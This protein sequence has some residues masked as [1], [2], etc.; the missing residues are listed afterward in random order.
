MRERCVPVTSF[1]FRTM[2]VARFSAG[3]IDQDAAH[4]LRRG[5]EKVRAIFKRLIT[6]TQPSFMDER[7]R[8]ERLAGLLARH[9]RAR[10]LAQLDINR[11]HQLIA[12]SRVPLADRVQNTC[13]FVHAM[14]CNV[15][16][17]QPKPVQIECRRNRVLTAGLLRRWIFTTKRNGDWACLTCSPSA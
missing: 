8:L 12:S 17:I 10:D 15:S 2:F 11:G 9:L 3:A 13:H 5:G 14:V 1:L 4:R 16:S 7:S 6:E